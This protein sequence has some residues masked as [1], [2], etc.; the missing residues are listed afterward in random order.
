VVRNG[1]DDIL[2]NVSSSCDNKVLNPVSKLPFSKR[3][4]SVGVAGQLRPSVWENSKDATSAPHDARRHNCVILCQASRQTEG[5]RYRKVLV[6]KLQ[7]ESVP[8][9]PSN[10]VFQ[11]VHQVSSGASRQQK[12]TV[13]VE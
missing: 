6:W 2:D 13:Q 7:G 9:R 5:G 11:V 1:A 4:G 3:G 8:P 10:W 12:S